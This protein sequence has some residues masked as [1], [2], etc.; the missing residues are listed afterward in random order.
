MFFLIV[1]MKEST[2]N[3]IEKNMGTH[4]RG[5]ECDQRILSKRQSN[6]VVYSPNYPFPYVPKIVCRYFVYGLQDPQDLERVRLSFEKFDVITN[7]NS[8]EDTTNQSEAKKCGDGFLKVY[9]KGQ[10]VIQA[11]DKAD[12]EF[13]GKDVPHDV[14]SDGPRLVLV[15]SS[16]E[17]VGSGFKAKYVFETEY[18]V[19][20]TAAPDGSCHFTYYS[21]SRMKGE[22]NSPRFPSNY[23]SMTNCTYMFFQQPNEQVRIVF[24]NFKMKSDKFNYTDRGAYGDLCEEDWVEVYNVISDAEDRLVGRYCG[25]TAPGPI[26][27]REKAQAL[28][29]I[30]H[31]D[32]E[33]VSSGFKARY[34]YFTAKT[35]F[36][37]CGQNITQAQSGVL[38]S[39]KWPQKYDGPSKGEGSATCNWYLSVRP[40]SRVM[41]HFQNFAIEG[42]PTGRGCPAAAVRIWVD[43]DGV[44]VELCGESLNVDNSQYV[45]ARNLMRVTFITADKA[46]GAAGFRAVW[47]EVQEVPRTTGGCHHS[48]FRCEKSLFCIPAELKCDGTSNCGTIEGIG[49]QSDEDQCESSF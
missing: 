8:E 35:I 45:S 48:Y 21:T 41:L 39:P 29:V 1:Q 34:I 23:P 38:T 7:I 32:T 13:C 14:V 20:G 18:R 27:S 17:A 40:G 15:F 26:E 36:G 44:P 16:G 3:F 12:Y 47:T 33:G 5:T 6:G 19:P 22:F 10:E 2:K 24:D 11:Y 49:D 9:L 4:I 31:T 25:S 28:K 42:E 46:V 37:E 43:P 30:L